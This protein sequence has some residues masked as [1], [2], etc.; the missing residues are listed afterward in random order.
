MSQRN[1]ALKAWTG[2]VLF[3]LLALR[4][5]TAC[6]AGPGEHPEIELLKQQI[7]DLQQRVEHLEGR[8]QQGGAESVERDLEPVTGGW[9][10]AHNWG[11]LSEG[12]TAYR[13]Q[14]V[15]GEPDQRKTVNKF[16]F[17]YYG[18]GKVRLYLRRLKNWDVPTGLDRP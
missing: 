7:L 16:E 5:W 9:R 1:P 18:D 13:V 6:A 14:E 8:L 10:K 12:M 4:S 15:L 3:A 2:V 17:W 11:L